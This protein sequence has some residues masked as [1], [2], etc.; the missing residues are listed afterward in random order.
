MRSLFTFYLFVCH[1]LIIL[2]VSTH[3]ATCPGSESDPKGVPRLR[4]R[5]MDKKTSWGAAQMFSLP[6]GW[7]PWLG[8]PVSSTSHTSAAVSGHGRAWLRRPGCGH[9]LRESQAHG[10]LPRILGAL[11]KRDPD[12]VGARGWA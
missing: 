7:V 8:P 5:Q 4:W 9:F 10:W 3:P 11:R 6:T 12:P 2:H 1:S